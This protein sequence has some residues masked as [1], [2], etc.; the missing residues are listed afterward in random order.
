MQASEPGV[1]LACIYRDPSELASATAVFLAEGF[2]REEPAV[3]VAT[4][5]HWPLF[6]LA[7]EER[8]WDTAEL[9]HRGELYV[10]DADVTLAAILDEGGSPSPQRFDL[11]IGELLDRAAGPSGRFVR[12]FGEMVDLLCKRG[13]PEAAADLEDIWNAAATQRRFSL[14]CGY[15][16]DIFDRDAQARVMPAV[17]SAH[18][19]VAPAPDL[20][21]LNSAVDRALVTT[22]G[23]YDAEKVYALAAGPRPAQGVPM[24]QLAL[25]W[26]TA[27]MPRTADRVL[28]AA[29][30]NYLAPPAPVAQT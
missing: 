10:V 5:A 4:E 12:A 1:H 30:Q 26:L 17:C 22:L 19:Q 24:S 3:V 18:S 20:D 23:A 9:E 11:V 29:R 2:E 21:L 28:E 16:L 13:N 25:M 6:S 8:G 14:L 7:L 27:H 15:G